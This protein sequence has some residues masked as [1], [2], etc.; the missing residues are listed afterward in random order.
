MLFV[1]LVGLATTAYVAPLQVPVLACLPLLYKAHTEISTN[2]PK[3]DQVTD[4]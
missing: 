1:K 2:P 3:S 4:T